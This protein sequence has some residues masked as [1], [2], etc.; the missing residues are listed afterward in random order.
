MGYGDRGW[1][2]S[3]SVNIGTGT[4]DTELVAAPGADRTLVVQLCI[5]TITT[6]AAQAFDIEDDAASPVELFKAPASLPAGTYAVDPGPV[7]I[8]LTANTALQFDT[9][10][11]GVGLTVS[12]FGYITKDA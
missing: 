8:R 1:Q 3:F 2:F 11:A 9:A 12:G 7:G 4:G 5:I 10:A 6:A